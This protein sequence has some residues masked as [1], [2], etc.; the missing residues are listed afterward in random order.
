MSNGDDETPENDSAEM[1]LTDVE[2]FET[3]LEEVGASLESAETEADLDDVEATLD[4]IETAL[5]SA[6]LPEPDE[7]EDDPSE[8]IESEIESL[9]SN[10]EDARGPY[11]EDVAA[12]VEDAA[13]TIRETRWTDQGG[14]DLETAVATFLDGLDDE[15]DADVDASGD[16]A[17]RL[18]DAAETLSGLSLDPDDD[19][20]QIETLLGLAQTL[21]DDVEAAQSWDDLTVQ[22]E[23]H[24]RGFY[25]ILTSERRKDYPPEWGAVKLYE[26]RY[27]KTG[28]SEAI[29]YILL[30]LEKLES[31]F[32][33]ENVLD[34]LER[35]GPPEAFDEMHQLAQKRNKQAIRV[36]GKIGDDAA[37]DTLVEFIDGDGDPAL[38]I[39]TLRALG[40][41]GSEEASQTIANRLAADNEDVRSAAARALGTIGDTRAIDPLADVLGDTEEAASVRASAAWALNTIATERALQAVQDNA[42]DASYLVQAEADKAKLSS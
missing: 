33:E 13:A 20:E 41:I 11:V 35:I 9:R 27:Q 14:E 21:E 40:A 37:V 6:E 1:A 15:L 22:E 30:A 39:V 24:E 42:D 36:L 29:E 12:L 17:D 4:A 32:M 16:A 3:R 8:E 38:Q 10:L 19:A 2:D 34:S 5:E 26:K 18:D 25:D 31:D 23:F 28:D 7:D